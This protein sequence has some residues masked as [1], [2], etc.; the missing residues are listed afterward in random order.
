M[1]ARWGLIAAAFRSHQ[2]CNRRSLILH[3]DTPP[4]VGLGS[5]HPGEYLAGLQHAHFVHI[6]T[7]NQSFTGIEHGSAQGLP[8]LAQQIGRNITHEWEAQAQWSRP[9]YQRHARWAS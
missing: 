1:H 9:W 3:I 2:R 6:A 8:Q 4:L 5:G 7:R